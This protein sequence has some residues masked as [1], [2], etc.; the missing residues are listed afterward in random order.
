[1]PGVS[2]EEHREL[3]R[4]DQ[5]IAALERARAGARNATEAA[6]IEQRIGRL[7]GNG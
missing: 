7:R 6:Q 4:R 5:A 3:G 2:L 1:M